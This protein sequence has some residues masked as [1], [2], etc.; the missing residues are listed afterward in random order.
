MELRFAIS[1]AM[2][3]TLTITN[4]RYKGRLKRQTVAQSCCIHMMKDIIH[5][6]QILEHFLK[7]ICN[8]KEAY[9]VL[10]HVT[11]VLY[12]YNTNHHLYYFQRITIC[13]IVLIIR[14]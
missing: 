12:I 11:K 13:R 14:D 3:Q 8:K 1:F 5:Y 7:E 4:N 9:S 6:F 2:V 10:Y